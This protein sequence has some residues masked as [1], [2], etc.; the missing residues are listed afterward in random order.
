M[1]DSYDIII[2]GGGI[3]GLSS[4]WFL[5]KAGVDVLV[6]EK[7]RLCSGG[8][9]AAGAFLSPKI[10]KPSP[11]KDYLNNAFRFSIDFYSQNFPD[12][13]YRCGL[14]K[15][16]LD[17]ADKIRCQHY[18]PTID[19]RWQRHEE[20]Y[21][22]PD[23]G[24]IDP[25]QLCSRLSEKIDII[26]EYEASCVTYQEGLWH[27]GRY[28]APRLLL[29]TGSETLPVPLPYLPIKRFGGYRYDVRFEE[30]EKITHTIYKDLSVSAAWMGRVI[31]GATYQRG[32]TPAEL[33]LS[34]KNDGEELLPRAQKIVKMENME[35]LGYETGF[36]AASFDL[37]PFVGEAIDHE[38]T[39]VRFPSVSRG[40][41]VPSK[42][43]IR[44]PG[45][46]LHTALGSRGF[47]F[48]PYNA[49]L[50]RDLIIKDQPIPEHL[51]PARRFLRWSRKSQSGSIST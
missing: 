50:L 25:Q 3:A 10:S 43:Y 37:F 24:L 32:I 1:R 15:L 29:A 7:R 4:A 49:A 46:Y 19:L 11:Y 8:S 40:A 18:E 6:L 5:Q 27:V 45:L 48:A 33:E 51:T 9:K 2:V 28:R 47:V 13:F 35:I 26:T 20:G 12:L 30:M 39:L 38:A 14:L 36:R 23:A 22:F 34:A 21:L 16:P 41:R 42:A 17:E 31:V 44:Y